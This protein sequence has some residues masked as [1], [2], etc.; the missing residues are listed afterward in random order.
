MKRH[1]TALC[2]GID[3]NFSTEQTDK[4]I[5]EIKKL[6]VEKFNYQPSITVVHRQGY[7]GRHVNSATGLKGLYLQ[8]DKRVDAWNIVIRNVDQKGTK[9]F[10]VTRLGLHVAIDKALEYWKTQYPY[11]RY[12]RDELIANIMYNIKNSNSTRYSS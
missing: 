3:S 7:P 2:V 10:G 6:M 5:G 1:D 11:I 8:L 4:I 9:S 12:N